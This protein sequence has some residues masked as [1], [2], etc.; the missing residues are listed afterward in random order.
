MADEVSPVRQ[1]FPGEKTKTPLLAK[2]HERIEASG[3]IPTVC[4]ELPCA[5]ASICERI[6]YSH[7]AHLIRSFSMQQVPAKSAEVTL[8]SV[9]L[10]CTMFAS[11]S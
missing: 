4:S 3:S 9:I 7:S 6:S 11:G 10:L 8:F 1:Y 5:N 2:A